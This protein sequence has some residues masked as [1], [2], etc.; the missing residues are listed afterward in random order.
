LVG[1][2]TAAASVGGVILYT[3]HAESGEPIRVLGIALKLGDGIM[4]LVVY[5]VLV[6]LVGVFSALCLYFTEWQIMRVVR[7]YERQCA[8][9]VL[10]I[11][12][13]PNY[14]GW[15]DSIGDEPRQQVARM[16]QVGSRFTAFVFRDL[17]RAILPTLTF[18]F[19]LVILIRVDHWLT[20]MLV[21]VALVYLGPLYF[22][23]R[24][25][26]RNQ[27]EYRA[28]A[29]IVRRSIS[30]RLREI[31]GFGVLG[32]SSRV[33]QSDVLS[34]QE[35]DEMS[36][37][38]YSRMIAEKRV[39]FL[40]TVFFVV[41]LLGLFLF[42]GLAAQWY[43]RP[44]ADLLSYLVALR[45]AIGSLRQ[46][47]ALFV[48][49]S[50]FFPEYRAYSQFVESAERVR[51][52]RQNMRRSESQLPDQL[53]LKLESAALWNA[54]AA[55]IINRGQL[56]WI[57]TPIEKPTEFE[58]REVAW[59]LSGKLSPPWDLADGAVFG[60]ALAV[61]PQASLDG[62]AAQIESGSRTFV[63]AFQT[64]SRMSQDFLDRLRELL[65]N[66]YIFLVEHRAETVLDSSWTKRLAPVAGVV[67]MD[68]RRIIAGGDLEW[69]ARNL[70]AV[71]RSLAAN[72]TAL[73]RHAD[74]GEDE[75]DDF[76]VI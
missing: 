49:F 8:K 12:A 37:A 56:L 71:Q 27:T 18:I 28:L 4:T 62:V 64:L 29:P 47:S 54:P 70:P 61:D 39:Q 21:P 50:R 76:E 57:L 75:D 51:R 40:N 46:V 63:I 42:F 53:M 17:L 33:A 36:G 19:A 67:V 7:E 59:R 5:G 34:N 66:C 58:L 25:V 10:E 11:A 24:R 43:D 74:L 45:F 32:Q 6:A 1:V 73:D 14:S 44:W 65:S 48:K 72:T 55:T 41:C 13:N 26:V 15:T 30:A 23:N 52:E 38:L 3:R 16:L 9:R 2:L 20:L 31:F 22:V 60:S 35:Y 69:L 68:Q